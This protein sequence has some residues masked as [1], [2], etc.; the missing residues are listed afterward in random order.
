MPPPPASGTRLEWSALPGRVRGAVEGWLG[1]P[2]ETAVTQA[3]GF[4]PGLAARLRTVRGRQVFVKAVGP[5]LNRESPAFHRREARIAAALP[6]A[7]PAPRL[8]WSHDEGDGGWVVL[9]YEDV[10][11][12][13]PAQPWRADQL[14][15]VLDAIRAMA[16]ALTPSPVSSEVG[17]TVGQWLASRGRGWQ[18]VLDRR[19][20]GLDRWSAR[21][22]A[23]LAALE[24]DAAPAAEGQTLLHFDIRADNLL[25]TPDRVVVVDWPH[26][27]LGADWVDVVFFAPSVA[28]QGGPSP[29]V[30]LARYLAGRTVDSAAVNAV[31]AAIA[32]FFT[33]QALQ[34]PPP[35]L[36]TLRAFQEAQGAVAR[37]W[38]ADRT[39]WR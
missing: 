34:P 20:A 17:G 37:R 1:E 4:S 10:A 5:E 3:G 19:P 8:L 28:M 18:Q 23:A 9:A 11:G 38:L 26:A 29:E 14:D 2:V 13:H 16:A 6:A 22:L 25:L 30:L 7:T 31:I 36:P 24:A 32:G 27:R 15:R 33:G 39:G 35:G 21:H 12:Q